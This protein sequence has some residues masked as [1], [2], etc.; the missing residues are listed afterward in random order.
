MHGILFV[1]LK[2]FIDRDL[3]GASWSALLDQTGLKGNFYLPLQDYPDDE[4]FSLIR[5]SSDMFGL[6]IQTFLMLFGQTMVPDLLSLYHRQIRPEWSLI[7]LLKHVETT[8]HSVVR[9]RNPRATPPQLR[10]KSDHENK[11]AIHYSS[12]R[13]L[14]SLAIGLI[15]G[16]AV[17]YNTPLY[18]EHPS[19][20]LHGDSEC[21]TV[22]SL[23]TKEEDQEREENTST[24]DFPR[25]FKRVEPPEPVTAENIG[26][27]PIII[28]GAGPIGVEATHQ[29][30][31]K[32][33]GGPV[34]LYGAEPWEPYNRVRLSELLAGDLEWEAIVAKLDLIS[35]DNVSLLMNNRIKSIDPKKKQIIECNGKRQSYS[36]LILA[37]GS[38]PRAVDT[39]NKKLLG[40]YTFRDIDDTQLL[41]TQVVQS[42]STVVLGGGI[43]GIEVAFALKQQNPDAE[44]ILLHRNAYL[45]NRE[46]DKETAD[47]LLLQVKKEGIQVYLNTSVTDFIGTASLEQ[48]RLSDGS[49]LPCDTL[50]SCIGTIP[51]IELAKDAG[52]ETGRGIKVNQYMQSSDPSIYAAGE[53]IEY[54]GKTYGT[55]APGIN[56]AV[57]AV[58]NIL[59]GNHHAYHDSIISMQAKIKHL[60]V[61][62]LTSSRKI[63]NKNNIVNISFSRQE[64]KRFRQL[65]IYNGRLVGA[66]AIGAWNEIPMVQEAIDKQARIWPWR[67]FYFI[68][69]GCFSPDSAASSLANLQHSSIIC[70]CSSVVHGE[71]RHAVAEGYSTLEELG[72][73]TG[74]G[75]NCGSCIPLLTQITGMSPDTVYSSPVSGRKLFLLSLVAVLP[76]ILLKLPNIPPPSSVLQKYSLSVVQQNH[77]FQQA[78]GFTA[79]FFL[80]FAQTLSINKRLNILN[81]LQYPIWRILHIVLIAIAGAVLLLH[82]NFSMGNR[83]S[84][85]MMVLFFIIVLSGLT[86]SS[87]ISLEKSF[88]GFIARKYRL[89]L[90]RIHYMF[91][92]LFLV[93]IIIHILVS[94][95]F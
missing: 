88:F 67:K 36:H 77:F 89:F 28:V 51:N 73:Q 95:Y 50:I 19:C 49:L 15:Q 44:V 75:K 72:A 64:N 80:L 48:I 16:L 70:S 45:M 35:T 9:L 93:S 71:L 58:D 82:T 78:S 23:K 26:S 27:D 11:V 86:L 81:F 20:M 17:E 29:I 57:V 7:E 59:Q 33:T 30:L 90:L 14:C 12:P 37:T 84:F 21:V 79:L 32:S 76:L 54:N 22:I 52:L 40:I 25:K 94:Y 68:R 41:L 55:V 65:S 83:F 69:Y 74:A 4:L 2:K 85:N 34:L 18:I 6:D 56:H 61:F 60:P 47:F 63:K 5:A 62:S 31:R 91:V 43:M 39:Q 10:I 3:G 66:K 92:P 46:L 1:Q 87:A 13:K 38:T 8:I 42:K 53:C 24:K